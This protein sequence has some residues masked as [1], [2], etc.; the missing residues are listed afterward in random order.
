MRTMSGDVIFVDLYIQLPIY[1]GPIPI[2]LGPCFFKIYKYNCIYITDPYFY[3]DIVLVKRL[4]N[5][6]F[7]H[8][9]ITPGNGWDRCIVVIPT[10]T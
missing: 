4:F 1:N 5:F 2:S 8:P 10:C 3:F 6:I 7:V 9:N